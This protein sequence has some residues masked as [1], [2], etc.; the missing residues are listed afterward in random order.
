MNNTEYD[1]NMI[2]AEIGIKGM[3]INVYVLFAFVN[4]IYFSTK[5]H[6]F[7]LKNIFFLSRKMALFIF[8]FSLISM[9]YGN[10]PEIGALFDL[11]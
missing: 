11:N 10:D 6:C 5:S 9:P 1:D 3:K 8:K 2:F 4:K 7:K